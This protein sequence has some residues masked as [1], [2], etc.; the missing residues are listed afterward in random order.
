VNPWSYVG[1]HE[2]TVRRAH[3][4]Q[5]LLG[6][7][8]L[9]W[10]PLLRRVEEP[11]GLR[12][13]TD[14]GAGEYEFELT[15]D[16][17]GYVAIPI[18]GVTPRRL[19]VTEAEFAQLDLLDVL[20]Q[21]RD[22]AGCNGVIEEVAGGVYQLGRR[23]VGG[24]TLALLAA[25]RGVNRLSA[26][27]RARLGARALGID[28]RVLLV[29]DVAS[30]PVSTLDEFADLKVAV[31]DLPNAP[32]WAVD[33][34]SL[35][36]DARFEV[37]LADPAFLLGTRYAVVVDLEQQRIWLE[38]KDLKVKADGQSYRLFA[39]LAERPMTGVPV[40]G[41]AN[42]VLEAEGTNRSE[43]KIVS[44]AKSELM[45]S[46]KIC[47]TPLPNHARLEAASIVTVDDGRAMLNVD[48]SLVR[49]IRRLSER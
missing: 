30:A 8:Y 33:W 19:N 45:K 18:D 14:F 3:D 37:P 34:S 10:A 36:L 44:D 5:R 12:F 11:A 15:V 6:S 43:A 35:V 49:V 2:R 39:H 22:T 48:P 16:V 31:T 24:K 38:G 29:P 4:W 21:I 17:D 28:V 1:R 20:G 27:E 46:I 23:M 40:Q 13:T 25:P 42:R 7:G 9:A 26:R 47:L 32:P 41:L